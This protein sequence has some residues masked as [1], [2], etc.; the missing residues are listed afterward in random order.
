MQSKF[1]GTFWKLLNTH[2][3]FVMKQEDKQEA[4]KM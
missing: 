1:L 3:D 2:Q 4:V